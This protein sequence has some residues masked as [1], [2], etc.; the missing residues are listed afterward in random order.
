MM[1]AAVRQRLWIDLQ[2]FADRV[3]LHVHRPASHD[4]TLP[5]FYGNAWF[6]AFPNMPI[7]PDEAHFTNLGTKYLALAI[8]GAVADYLQNE[9][10]WQTPA[11]REQ[12]QRENRR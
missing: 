2:I 9:P 12:Q 5:P 3:H 10:E 11:E 7:E 6:T 1:D 8:A 4:G